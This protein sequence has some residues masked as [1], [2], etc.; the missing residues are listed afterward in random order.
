MKNFVIGI[1]TVLVV[2]LGGYLV[3]DKV[4][5]KKEEVK[6]TNIEETKVSEPESVGNSAYSVLNKSF[7]EHKIVFYKTNEYTCK[8]NCGV[9]VLNTVYPLPT[10]GSPITYELSNGKNLIYIVECDSSDTYYDS[11]YG[12]IVYKD[13]HTDN[14][15]TATVY[16]Y[17]VTNSKILKEYKNVVQTSNSNGKIT[18][19]YNNGTTV[20]PDIQ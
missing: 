20:S 16:L 19:K 12:N 2:A 8:N 11:T 17:D 18:L 10:A 6:E 4:I 1:L 14:N 13:G 7:E 3:Y 9:I 5:D 15:A